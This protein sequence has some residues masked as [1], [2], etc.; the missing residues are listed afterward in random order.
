MK[1]F[2]NIGIALAVLVLA[3]AVSVLPSNAQQKGNTEQDQP[4]VLAQNHMMSMP[5]MMQ[6]MH[7]LMD[8]TSQMNNSMHGNSIELRIHSSH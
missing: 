7:Q 6:K 3:A 5:E 1:Y 2:K 4:S 8:E